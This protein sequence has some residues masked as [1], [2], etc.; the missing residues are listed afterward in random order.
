MPLKPPQP[1][2]QNQRDWDQ[3]ARSVEV[4]PNNDSTGTDQLK[5]NAVTNAKLDDMPALSVKA[6]SAN[7]SGDPVD[8]EAST[9]GTFLQRRG[10]LLQ[11]AV[12][13]T[14]DITADM[15]TQH[16]NAIRAFLPRPAAERAVDDVQVMLA[17]RIF[18]AR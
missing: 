18:R 11:W 15:I 14:G 10:D 4:V 9:N 5:D 17:S 8:L 13:Q 6:R 1:V 7:S 16:M 3:W 12:L 2:P